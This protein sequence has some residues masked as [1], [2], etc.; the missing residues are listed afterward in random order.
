MPPTLRRLW[1]VKGVGR[2]GD[3]SSRV[4]GPGD[5]QPTI[6]SESL[7]GDMIAGLAACTLPLAFRLRGTA[8][9]VEVAVGTWSPEEREKASADI[10]D[11]RQEIVKAA[12]KSIL[13]AVDLAAADVEVAPFDRSCLV[14]GIPSTQRGDARDGAAATDR[15]IRGLAGTLWSVLIL[16]EPVDPGAATV[17]RNAALRE[18]RKVQSDQQ[19]LE[20]SD[21][22]VELYAGILKQHVTSLTASISQGAWRT[23]VYLSGNVD[24]YERVVG[25]WKGVFAG[26]EVMREPIRIVED[27]G[28]ETLVT[29]WRVPDTPGA[30]GPGEFVHPLAY[31]SILTSAELGR[32][33]CLPQAEVSGFRV[34]DMP[35]FDLM[36][37]Q[38]MGPNNFALGEI[39]HANQPVGLEYPIDL[40]ALAK[41]TFVA[42]VTGSGKTT[43]IMRL[44]T[45][46]WDANVPFLVIEPAKTEYRQLLGHKSLAEELRVFTVGDE[47]VA[48]LR[49]NPFEVV[50]GASVAEHI[51]WL[52][53]LFSVSF[54]LWTPL[55]QILERCLHM[56]YRDH[57]W[58][59]TSNCNVRSSGLDDS[60]AFPTM[61]DLVEKVEE[62]I[63]TLGFDEEAVGRIRGSLLTRLRGLLMG[64]KGRMFNVEVS[65]GMAALFD[66]PAIVELER[67]GDDDDKAFVMGLL[68]LR[69]VEYRRSRQHEREHD[70]GAESQSS[71]VRHLL[72]F[73]EAHRL[74]A[75]TVGKMGEGEGSPRAKAVESFA[76]LLSE[77]RAYRQG[78]IVADQVPVKLAS[79][80]IKNTSLKIA[81]RVVDVED[82]EVLAGA[83]AMTAA[84]EH[85]LATLL[86]GRAAVYAE[87]DDAPI[88]VHIHELH[89]GV[90]P[91]DETIRT[92]MRKRF[93]ASEPAD[94]YL[95]HVGC[96]DV[97]RAAVTNGVEG[98]AGR[99]CEIAQAIA[100]GSAF[101]RNYARWVVSLVA[102]S[103]ANVD[104]AVVEDLVNPIRREVDRSI[105]DPRIDREVAWDCLSARAGLWFAGRRGSQSEWPF[106]KTRELAFE[107]KMLMLGCVRGTVTKDAVLRT[108]GV[109]GALHQRQGSP[110]SRCEAIC[111]GPA[112]CLYRYPVADII[113]SGTL[114]TIWDAYSRVDANRNTREWAAKAWPGACWPAAETLTAWTDVGLD[115]ARRRIGLCYAQT[116]LTNDVSL[117]VNR[118]EEIM[119]QLM[120]V[121][122]RKAG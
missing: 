46:V 1:W 58:D 35:D 106:D 7:M 100:A 17:F 97:N 107:L 27:E 56:T 6:S 30:R 99:A 20:M 18:L 13:P 77:I 49:L 98:R 25:I 40:A 122:A 79:D 120:A 81:H 8:T 67:L 57:G 89:L 9:G 29:Q 121:A 73:E 104:M 108:I 113:A 50:S 80:V 68:L 118:A 74:L 34:F 15:L 115:D 19:A 114:R 82:R 103:D 5:A 94:L 14:I 38:E 42:G 65:T 119:D 59:I 43:T 105:M 92:G 116:I 48:P 86:P 87:G 62:V 90:K 24:S 88:L 26:N 71:P 84:Q 11:A 41:H 85:G 60:M 2:G 37:S 83:M 10:L 93:I 96:R 55:P 51:D 109:Y 69:L 61:A 64:G 39:L 33:L 31:Q 45:S 110:Y 102:R 54:G 36:P 111:T 22:M 75:R 53:S 63:P 16:A 95:T 72:I 28:I 44:L 21:P 101:R 66:R 52:R 47:T 112:V 70:G 23:A 3:K 32:Y 78:V 91:N 117:R 4:A 12:L 76:N